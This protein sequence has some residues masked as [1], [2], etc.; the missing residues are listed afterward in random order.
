M[1][2]VPHREAVESLPFGL[3]LEPALV[4]L[5]LLDKLPGPPL[6]GAVVQLDLAEALDRAFRDE[7][8]KEAGFASE[9]DLGLATLREARQGRGK[10]GKQREAEQLAECEHPCRVQGHR[11][12]ASSAYARSMRADALPG[13]SLSRGIVRGGVE[14]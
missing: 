7:G 14:A 11:G 1:S 9:V 8:N 3:E 10:A 12:H 13:M 5:C 6:V 2:M 4:R